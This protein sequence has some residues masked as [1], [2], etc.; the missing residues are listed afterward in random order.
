M[1]ILLQIME[2]IH[3][4]QREVFAGAFFWCTGSYFY[5]SYGGVA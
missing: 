1:T 2:W 3:T 5:F 4:Y